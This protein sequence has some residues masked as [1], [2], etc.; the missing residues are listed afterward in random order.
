MR[1]TI[2]LAVAALAGVL[3]LA[4]PAAARPDVPACLIA[5]GG[6]VGEFTKSWTCV[7]LV[8]SG[9]GDTGSGRYSAPPGGGRHTLTV[10]VEYQKP[11]HGYR[12]QEALWV[13]LA[14]AVASGRGGLSADTPVVRVPRQAVLRACVTVSGG[15]RTDAALCS[16]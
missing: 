3:G 11:G 8:A 15:Y 12:H 10:T 13:P 2:T 4:L 7:E 5:N 6:Q 16:R 9:H 1:R 14:S